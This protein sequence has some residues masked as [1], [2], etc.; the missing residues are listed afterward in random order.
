MKIRE[1]NR[2]NIDLG[3]R[4]KVFNLMVKRSAEELLARMHPV[5]EAQDKVQRQR[6]RYCSRWY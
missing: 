1:E 3:V 4:D 5:A 2:E 6:H